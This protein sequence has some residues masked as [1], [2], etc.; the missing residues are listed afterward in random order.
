MDK[1]VKEWRKHID[2]L[3]NSEE[4]PEILF[5]RRAIQRRRQKTAKWDYSCYVVVIATVMFL[6]A[7]GLGVF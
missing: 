1:A 5:L 4:A 6:A 7:W 3:E 2:S